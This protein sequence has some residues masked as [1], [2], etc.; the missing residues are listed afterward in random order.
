MTRVLVRRA[1]LRTARQFRGIGLGT[2][3]G[4]PDLLATLQSLPAGLTEL[5]T[6]PGHPDDE[7]ARLTVFSEGRD[8]ELAALTAPAAREVVRRRRIRLTSFAMFTAQPP[9]R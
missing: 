1:G 7:L 9:A 2:G 4:E 5:M 3:F 8:R 6:H